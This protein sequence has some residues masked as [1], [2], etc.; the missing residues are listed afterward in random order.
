MTWGVPGTWVTFAAP[1]WRQGARGLVEFLSLPR[2]MLSPSWLRPTLVCSLLQHR[3][4]H[5][6]HPSAWL[7]KDFPHF[8]N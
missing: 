6:Q 3:V 7:G 5:P 1:G 4:P 8:F 2:R